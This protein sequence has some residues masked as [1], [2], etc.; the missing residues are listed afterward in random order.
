LFLFSDRVGQTKLTTS[1]HYSARK[2]SII[3]V[4]VAAS[5]EMV[6]KADGDD[7]QNYLT[8]RYI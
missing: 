5:Q 8:S 6:V 7:K 2:H 4:F 1:Q 3:V